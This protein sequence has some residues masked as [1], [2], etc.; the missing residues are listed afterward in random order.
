MLIKGRDGF[1]T[2]NASATSHCIPLTHSSRSPHTIPVPTNIFAPEITQLLAQVRTAAST[3][4]TKEVIVNG[5][6]TPVQ[7]PYPSPADWRDS[8]IYF[9]LL[10]RFANDQAPPRGSWNQRFNFRHGG[11]FRG[12]TAQLDYLRDLGA[13]AIW[14]SPILKNASPDWEYNYHGYGIQDFVSIDERFASDGTRATGER[15]LIELVD[16]AHARGLYIIFDI[17]INHAA[18][19]FDYVYEGQLVSSFRDPKV[20]VA[21]PGQEPPI[22]WLDGLGRAR[23]E[24]QNEVPLGAHLSPDD[25]VYPVDLRRKIFFRC[26]GE[27]LSDAVASG[28]FA[29][30]DFGDMRQLVVEFDASPESQSAIRAIYGTTP[31]LSIL[32]LA[33]QFIMA[34]FDV[35]GFRIDAVK[36]VSPHYVEMFGNAIREFAQTMGKRNFF[37]FG[38]IYDNEDTIA[39]FVGRDSSDADGFGIDAALDFPLFFKLPRIVKA[40]GDEGVEAIREIFEH[41]KIA[42]KTLI[43]SHGEAGKYFVTFLDNHDQPERF[44][45]PL[46]LQNQVTLG[47]AVLFCLQGI[48]AIYYGTEQGLSGTIDKSGNPDLGTNES[49]REAL[50]GKP[51]GLD[52]SHFMFQQIKT[53]SLLRDQQPALRFG[54]L[55]FREVSGNGVDFGH[56]FGKGELLAFSRI[57]SDIEVLVVANTNIRQRFDGFVVQDLALNRSP[58]QMK[59]AYSNI[60]VAGSGTVTKVT[61]ARFF[62]RTQFAGTAD[63]AALLVGLAPMELQVLAPA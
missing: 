27:K 46:T 5:N 60:G 1:P 50:W 25:A 39:Q 49:V 2:Y 62:S 3:K 56:S 63:I 10:D 54:R 59:I 29:K 24:W 36:H 23:A 28:S 51:D 40:T 31:V 48:P 14:L 37:T 22:Q 16:Q 47:I 42:E 55:Y 34:K 15:E 30:G 53:L 18:R 8:W 6:V 4:T 12:V 57:L 21:P 43:S 52:R 45:H 44:N 26:R 19:V 32:I 11:T 38:E 9:L 41:R 33:Y 13:K 61:P 7:Y 17:V 35:D 20:T 58:R